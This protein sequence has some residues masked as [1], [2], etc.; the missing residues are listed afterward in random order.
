MPMLQAG[1]VAQVQIP[2]Q[3]IVQLYDTYGLPIDLMY[4]MLAEKDAV[5]Y[6]DSNNITTDVN[7]GTRSAEEFAQIIQIA[8]RDKSSEEFKQN[9]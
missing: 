7:V 9:C 8:I 1:S 6:K 3:C 5:I 4:V 2:V